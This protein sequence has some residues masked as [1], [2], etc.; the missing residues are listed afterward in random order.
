MA[1]CHRFAVGGHT[2]PAS[3]A[4]EVGI[5]G[6]PPAARESRR[7]VALPEPPNGDKRADEVGEPTKDGKSGERSFGRP[8]V[9]DHRRI[10][11]RWREPTGRRSHHHGAGHARV[12]G[13]DVAVCPLDRE[14]RRPGAPARDQTRIER[15]TV[16]GGAVRD[17]VVIRPRDTIADADRQRPRPEGEVPDGDALVGGEDCRHSEGENE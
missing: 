15:P 7:A 10:G 6:S 13:A 4:L 16:G 2:A 11:I 1:A 12:R 17:A 9:S 5:D 8:R 3:R 14:P